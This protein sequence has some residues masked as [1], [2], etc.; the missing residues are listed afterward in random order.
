MLIKIIILQNEYKKSVI[1]N[2][3]SLLSG[4]IYSTLIK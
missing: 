3:E 2:Q 1:I 4:V